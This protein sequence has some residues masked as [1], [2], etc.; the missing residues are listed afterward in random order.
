MPHRPPQKPPFHALPV[1]D[2]GDHPE[3]VMRHLRRHCPRQRV[4]HLN[5]GE[6]ALDHMLRQCPYADPGKSPEPHVIDLDAA[7]SYHASR[8]VV[9]SREFEEF[10]TLMKEIGL[11]WLCCGERP[12]GLEGTCKA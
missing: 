3:L 1:E 10:T 7:C 6:A 2:D 11:Y 4:I 9:K 12:A 8:Y 5:D